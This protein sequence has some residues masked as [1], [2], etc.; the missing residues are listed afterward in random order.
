MRCHC[1]SSCGKLL[2]PALTAQTG[3]MTPHC[4]GAFCKE[5]ETHQSLHPKWGTRGNDTSSTT[6]SSGDQN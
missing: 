2:P 1:G 3:N 5:G 6:P 4:G